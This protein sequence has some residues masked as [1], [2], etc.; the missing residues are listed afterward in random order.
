MS[1]YT[2]FFVFALLLG[3]VFCVPDCPAA[4]PGGLAATT[5]SNQ[6]ALSFV[7]ASPSFYTV[8]VSSDLQHW[9]NSP[10]GFAGDGTVKTV[11]MPDAS[12]GGQ[13]F[14]RLLIQTPTGLILPQGTAQS[15]LI[16]SCGGI[17]EQVSAGLDVTNGYPT[18]VVELSTR[19]GGSGKGGGYHVTTYTA[20]VAVTWDFTG[21]VISAIPMTN[22]VTVDP[23][24]ATDSYG[25]AVYNVGSAAYLVVPLPAAPTGVTSVQSNDQFQVSWTPNGVNPLAITS[26]TLSATP[27]ASTNP[28]LTV[29]V[30]GAA[31]TGVIPTLQPQT[32]YQITVA[33]TTIGGTGPG[34]APISIATSAATVLPS[35]PT[36][37]AASWQVA[38]P[39]G[40]TDTIVATWQPANPGN[41]PIDQYLVTVTGGGGAGMFTQTV[42][43]TTLTAYFSVNDVPNWSVTV[44]AH[45]AAGW[46]PSSSAVKLG[47][48]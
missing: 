11:P 24:T 9:T 40:S 38:D 44:Q 35:A 39:S 3:V 47:G 22:G 19:C 48:L 23:T 30:A 20:A 25:D 18:G 15:I 6:L 17:Q 29:T 14:Y 32:T 36:G 42:S 34:S 27:V 1:R 2:P 7:A 13:G 46:G 33:S 5:S 45:N 31:T 12:A 4:V 28:V 10:P 41:S 26:S 37:V 16:Y 8:Q 43:G 21:N